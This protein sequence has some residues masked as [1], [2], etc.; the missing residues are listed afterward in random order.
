MGHP[1][2][3]ERHASDGS[4]SRRGKRK[5]PESVPRCAD[6]PESGTLESLRHRAA[7][8][9]RQSEPVH[10]RAAGASPGERNIRRPARRTRGPQHESLLHQPDRGYGSR[11]SRL[12][13]RQGSGTHRRGCWSRHSQCYAG[14]ESGRR[15]LVDG[16]HVWQLCAREAEPGQQRA[17]QFQRTR[18]RT[19]GPESS[20]RVQSVRR[21]I[22][23][24]RGDARHDPRERPVLAEFPAE[25]VRYHRRRPYREARGHTLQAR[26]RRRL[27]SPGF[28][29]FLD[30]SHRHHRGQCK[31]QPHSPVG[32][33]PTRGADLHREKCAT[34]I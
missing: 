20:H 5:S 13:L 3:T 12:Q 33:R 28:H 27:A 9:R 23:Y 18:R 6:H 11:R 21:W 26:G 25:D 15:C 2:R 19:R 34:S 4:R 22:V 7:S 24:E 17:A 10:G 8:V 14:P 16:Q 32:V 31:P 1:P 30:L 29:N